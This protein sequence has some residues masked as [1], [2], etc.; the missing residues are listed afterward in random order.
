VGKLL[1]YGIKVGIDCANAIR[2][3]SKHVMN[4]GEHQWRAMKR[5][6][7]YLKHKKKHELTFKKPKKISPILFCDSNYGANSED[8]RSISGYIA[9][10]GGMITSWSSQTQ[11]IVCLSSTEAEYVAM[12]SC[13]QE[14]IF[15]Q[16]LL[17]ELN[18]NTDPMVIYED[19]QGAIFL[20]E[21]EQVSKITKHIDIR[22]HFIRDLVRDN[23]LKIKYIESEKNVSDILTK[24][25]HRNV[26]EGHQWNIVNGNTLC[27]EGEC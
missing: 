11:Q 15:Q 17:Q 25:V 7:G 4:P 14:A 20:S 6:I 21:N 9:T 23:K 16:Q 27:I 10:V 22:Y 3:L 2:D 1:Y 24:N 5:I 18:L 13:T 8:R 19:N 12:T 26:F